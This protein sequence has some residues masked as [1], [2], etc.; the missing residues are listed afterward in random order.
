[1]TGIQ[2]PGALDLS[3]VY[4]AAPANNGRITA[5][6]NNLTNTTVSYGYDQL[7]RL[8]NAASATG[9]TTNWGLSFSYDVYGNRTAQ[10]VTAGSAPA[11]SA[12]FDSGNHMVGYSYDNN[13]N[14][15]N[16]PDGATLTYDWDNRMTNW[17]LS[18]A[19][20]VYHYHP[21]GWR[22]WKKKSTEAEGALYLYGPGGQL[23]HERSDSGSTAADYIYFGGRLLYTARYENST[24][25]RTGMYVDR[26]GTVRNGGKSYYP[27]GEEI[28]TPSANNTY[29]FASTYRDSATGLDYAINRYYASGMG[30]FLSADPYQASGGP[31][32]PQNWNRYSYVHNDP[33]NYFDPWGTNE[34]DPNTAP[35]F[36]AF[37]FGFSFIPGTAEGMPTLVRYGPI[38]SAGMPPA[39]SASTGGGLTPLQAAIA[40]AR[41][42]GVA[43]ILNKPKCAGL[44]G[45]GMSAAALGAMLARAA[46]QGEDLGPTL[47]YL[48]AP[49]DPSV[50][51]RYRVARTEGGT[52]F[53]NTH[54]GEF[55]DP[56]NVATYWGGDPT[57]QAGTVNLLT[58]GPQ[59]GLTAPQFRTA[60]IL[61]ELGHITK[62][63]ADDT[64][65]TQQSMD[66]TKSVIDNCIK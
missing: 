30:R 11:F 21:A 32:V 2:V 58:R 43:A 1:L 18:G 48:P 59:S 35:P 33:I 65:N 49:E 41:Q 39:P 45:N 22:I 3:Y 56:A 4:P 14:Q 28:G 10:A 24:W 31:A 17:S 26:L 57:S 51:Y 25:T 29:K 20:E 12:T 15:L 63:F 13:G 8:A 34:A 27:F 19:S 5:E 66:F 36:P 9:G 23:L 16:T 44:L 53:V 46:I 6:V 37:G 52:I 50:E 60:Y 40:E 55:V 54:G 42:A 7:N 47:E 62:A 61:H 38:P 64:G